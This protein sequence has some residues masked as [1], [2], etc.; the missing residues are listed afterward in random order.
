[1]TA[2]LQN[3][4][5]VLGVSGGIA[6]YKAVELLRLYTQAGASVRVIMTKNARWFVGPTT[7]E[8][9]S[10]RPVTVDLF[11]E[12]D[13][14]TIRHIDWAIEA[15]AAIIAP[16][17]ANIIG[18]LANGIADDALSTFLTAVISPKIV[19]P[20]MNT[21][22]F[23]SLPVQ[24]N[25]ETLRS[26]GC[27]V[28]EPDAGS[29]ACGTVGPGRL[30]APEDILDRTVAALTPKDLDG[31]R[32]LVTAGPTREYIDPVRFISNPSSG[33]MGHAIARAAEHRGA[34]VTLVSGPVSLQPPL[35]VD[36]VLIETAEEMAKKVLD[37]AQEIDIIIK[38]SA[39]GDFR[40]R[41]AADQKIKKTGNGMTLE[42]DPNVDILKELGR[43]KDGQV[44][45]GFAAETEDLVAN[46]AKKLKEKNLD[47]IAGNL[48]GAGDSGFEA[49][50]NK[51]TLF[52][53]D[54]SSESLPLMEKDDVAH[55]LLDRVVRLIQ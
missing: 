6:A 48:I 1:M 9:L 54:G 25:L 44:L 51:V 10:G 13:E 47:V 3:K 34:S 29:L 40:P 11:E 50:T 46:A 7:F 5:L 41:L 39:V 36:V 27:I 20:A 19:C 22:M 2:R 31:K 45:V 49:D 14:T 32:V 43:R 12:G 38:T 35:N 28:V 55:Q 18:K 16:A 21:H 52:Y 42:L 17:T 23:E 53:K 37:I 8:A 26:D 24:R 33:K 4:H 15:D 30:P